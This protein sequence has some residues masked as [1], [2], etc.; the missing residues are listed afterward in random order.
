M[1][2]SGHNGCS[3]ADVKTLSTAAVI[4]DGRHSMVFVLNV[5][6]GYGFV[7]FIKQL[8]GILFGDICCFPDCPASLPAHFS[9]A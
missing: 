1:K 6:L 4:N 9:T 7:M 8:Y 3:G 2:A 5:L